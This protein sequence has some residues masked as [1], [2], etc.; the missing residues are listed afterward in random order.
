MWGGGGW[1]EKTEPVPPTAKDLRREHIKVC[2]GIRPG[3]YEHGTQGI[4]VG[5]VTEG[6]PAETAGVKEVDLLIQWDK[7]EVTDVK[8]W[9]CMLAKHKVGDQLKVVVLRDEQRVKLDVTLAPVSR[10]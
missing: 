1:V 3:S 9:M 5:C 2:F 6:G 4:L 7:H 8:S 10:R